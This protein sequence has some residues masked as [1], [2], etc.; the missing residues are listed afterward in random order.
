VNFTSTYQANEDIRQQ[1]RLYAIPQ[2]KVASRLGISETH[3]N[4]LLR[5]ELSDDYRTRTLD[6]IR[7][8]SQEA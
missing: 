6:A 7:E 1:M 5:L 8:L 2:W 3:F 4:R